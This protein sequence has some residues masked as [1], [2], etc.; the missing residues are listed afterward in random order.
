MSTN[1]QR[2]LL[3]EEQ[4]QHLENHI[5]NCT[6]RGFP[7]T[8]RD[9]QRD[10]MHILKKFPSS[11]IYKLKDGVPGRRW[12]A[13][14]MKRHPKLRS[15]KLE[16][17]SKSKPKVDSKNVPDDSTSKSLK[18]HYDVP[19]PNNLNQELQEGIIEDSDST[20]F[21]ESDNESGPRLPNIIQEFNSNLLNSDNLESGNEKEGQLI[22]ETSNERTEDS[23]D[24]FNTNESLIHFEYDDVTE[25]PGFEQ[26]ANK[27]AFDKIQKIVGPQLNKML[28]NHDFQEYNANDFALKKI[29]LTFKP[30]ET[31]FAV[32]ETP[33][34]DRMIV[35][36]QNAH[37]SLQSPNVDQEIKVEQ[38][39]I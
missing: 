11:H 34:K 6:L 26:A 10:A 30:S 38:M 37:S 32:L 4:E 2:T 7:K 14:F 16:A 23:T 9:I 39:Q 33:N 21:N 29:Y 22:S 12:V 15:L 24:D 18:T 5:I 25:H 1:T 28:Y 3:T 20:Q 36:S 13:G 19:L 17:N 31:P 35:S 8:I 27:Y